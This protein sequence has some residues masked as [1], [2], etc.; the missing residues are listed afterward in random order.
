MRQ[1]LQA[2]FFNRTLVS[3]L[4]SYTHSVLIAVERYSVENCFYPIDPHQL[5]TDECWGNLELINPFTSQK[6]E[7]TEYEADNTYCAIGYIPLI[8]NGY[9]YSFYMVA[10][11]PE[12]YPGYDI[13]KDGEPD[14]IILTCAS[15]S[16]RIYGP[17]CEE[18]IQ[19]IQ[20]AGPSPPFEEAI[21]ELKW[22]WK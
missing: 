13:D 17:E 8:Y 22:V 14:H 9:A 15:G 3:Q 19:K 6:M 16:D 12:N 11:G 20:G 5:E 10:F 7:L 2:A 1:D 21:K 18:Y 4:K